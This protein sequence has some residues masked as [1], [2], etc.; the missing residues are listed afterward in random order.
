MLVN[1]VDEKNTSILLRLSNFKMTSLW[2]FSALLLVVEF[3][4]AAAG[5]QSDLSKI[6]PNHMS[7]SVPVD[8]AA[9]LCSDINM[10]YCQTNFNT[11]LNIQGHADWH[12][13]AL[14]SSQISQ[15][16]SNNG[17]QGLV[18]ICS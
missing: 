14:L 12:N 3:S 18:S 8:E 1:N 16:L 4:R 15:I 2:C 13:P 9:T 6:V 10:Y 7:D 5:F 17:T 11:A